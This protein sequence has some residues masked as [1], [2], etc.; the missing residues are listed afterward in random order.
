MALPCVQI[1]IFKHSMWGQEQGYCTGP[2]EPVFVNLVR[3]P[4][5]DSQPG[6]R[7][8]NPIRRTG[9][10]GYIGW[11][12]RFLGSLN[13]YKFWLSLTKRLQGEPLEQLND[14]NV[15]DSPRMQ[16]IF[17]ENFYRS[18]KSIHKKN[19]HF[20]CKKGR[21]RFSDSDQNPQHCGTRVGA[22]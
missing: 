10:P 17:P 1:G 13:V 7:Y 18:S 21:I 6:G 8:E 16:K 14:V 2:P 9:P 12:N 19:I 5:I 15:E 22:H 11:R 4:G 20:L 3:I